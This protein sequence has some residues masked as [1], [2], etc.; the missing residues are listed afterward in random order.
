MLHGWHRVYRGQ[1]EGDA[2]KIRGDDAC[3]LSLIRSALIPR[4]T[5]QSLTKANVRD[6]DHFLNVE[7]YNMTN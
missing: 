4:Q 1:S 6:I 5:Q 2:S 3:V 7:H